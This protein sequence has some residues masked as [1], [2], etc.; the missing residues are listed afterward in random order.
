MARRGGNWDNRPHIILA[1]VCIFHGEHTT[2]GASNHSR[3]LLDSHVVHDEFMNP[4][5]LFSTT[6]PLFFGTK[7]ARKLT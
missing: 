1:K 6:F 7:Y 5:L 3:D 2:H 4:K